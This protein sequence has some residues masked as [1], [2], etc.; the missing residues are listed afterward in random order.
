MNTFKAFEYTEYG[1]TL[2][3]SHLGSKTREKSMGI[4]LKAVFLTFS[5][6]FT[7]IA[8]ADKNISSLKI[9]NCH[10]M[11]KWFVEIA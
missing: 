7:E 9:V 4:H 10:F 3:K 2:K 6:I 1:N 11:T 8:L 5:Q